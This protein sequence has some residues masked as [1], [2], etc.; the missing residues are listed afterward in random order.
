MQWREP[1]QHTEEEEEE[2]EEEK[3]EE[4][5]KNVHLSCAHE[6]P[7]SSHDTY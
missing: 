5:K 2:E 7:E 4:E 1:R 6:R 3:E